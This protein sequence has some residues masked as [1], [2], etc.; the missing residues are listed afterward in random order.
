MATYHYLK[1]VAPYEWTIET[2]RDTGV[3]HKGPDN[4]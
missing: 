4:H 1:T 2:P 3:A